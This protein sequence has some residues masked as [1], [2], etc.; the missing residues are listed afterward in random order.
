MDGDTTAP[1]THTIPTRLIA[2]GSGEIAPR[3]GRRTSRAG[4]VASG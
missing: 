2:R 4:S 1:L 3:P